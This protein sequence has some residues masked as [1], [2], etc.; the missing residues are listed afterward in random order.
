MK[1]LMV[2]KRG[3]VWTVDTS[4]RRKQRVDESKISNLITI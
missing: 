1:K 4:H 2:E 3:E